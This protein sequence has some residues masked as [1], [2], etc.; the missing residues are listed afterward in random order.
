MGEELRVETGQILVMVRRG[1][2]SIIL[3][4][5]LRRWMI[6][7]EIYS[8]ICFREAGKHMGEEENGRDFRRMEKEPTLMR[9]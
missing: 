1:I 9:M 5:V 6:Y 7:L 2:A 8:M 4:A 3:L